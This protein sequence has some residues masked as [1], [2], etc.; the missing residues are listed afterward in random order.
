MDCVQCYNKDY[1]DLQGLFHYEDRDE[2]LA[3]A[4]RFVLLLHGKKAKC[5]ASLDDLRYHLA[6]TTD[7]SLQISCRLLKTHLI[8]MS[9]KHSTKLKFG[10]KAIYQNL[11]WQVL[12]AMCG[13]YQ[14]R[15]S[16]IQCTRR[17]RPPLKWEILRICIALT[18]RAL[19][20]NVPVWWQGCHALIFVFE[21][22]NLHKPAESE[23][24]VSTDL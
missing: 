19:V 20:R 23:G 15:E 22:Q 21:C 8:N 14:N 11:K 7:H 24:E 18:K 16:F 6:T 9:H 12:W 5:L 1:Q 13:A 10:I 2:F 3:S 17:S 4:R